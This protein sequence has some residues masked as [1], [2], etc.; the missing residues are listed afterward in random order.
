M[1]P[2]CGNL[3]SVITATGNELERWSAAEHWTIRKDYKKLV[4]TL[5]NA[6][7]L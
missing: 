4:G 6:L 5:I 2:K 7:F 1:Q 3:I